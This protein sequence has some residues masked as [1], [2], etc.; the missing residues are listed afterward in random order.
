MSKRQKKRVRL[1]AGNV[2]AATDECTLCGRFVAPMLFAP[3]CGQSGRRPVFIAAFCSFNIS[4]A[5]L[6]NDQ[7]MF[8]ALRRAMAGTI[9]A[10]PARR[11]ARSEREAP[12]RRGAPA[13]RVRRSDLAPR[14][15]RD[16]SRKG[17]PQ[18]ALDRAHNLERSFL[19]RNGSDLL[20]RD[21][22]PCRQLPERG[23]QQSDALRL[24][25]RLP[26][27]HHPQVQRPRSPLVPR[28][29]RSAASHDICSFTHRLLSSR[30]HSYRLSNQVRQVRTLLLACP[31]GSVHCH[32][33]HIKQGRDYA[34]WALANMSCTSSLVNSSWTRSSG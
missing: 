3:A 20:G 4:C 29:D 10:D 14:C 16:V 19:M 6:R 1:A 21:R 5:L 12:P 22:V 25:G 17:E 23:R 11:Q 27:L 34:N 18:P 7:V 2:R 28:S 30:C 24:C 8:G 32:C 33:Y 13:W 26:A 15:P 9:F 31:H